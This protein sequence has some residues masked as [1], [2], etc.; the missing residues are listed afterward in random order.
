VNERLTF[1][2][3]VI[4]VI[5]NKSTTIDYVKDY[6]EEKRGTHYFLRAVVLND[7]PSVKTLIDSMP[8]DVRDDS[9]ST[10]LM[11]AAGN[12]NALELTRLL[13]AK[14]DAKFLHAK[15]GNALM[16]A[17]SDGNVE[18]VKLLMP[19]SDLFAKDGDGRT[20]LMHAARYGH[21]KI[22]SMLLP[23]SDALE[24][25][26]KG[27]NALMHAARGKH[28]ECVDKLKKSS[29]L[30]DK[31]SR[32]ETALH[33]AVYAQ[34][35]GCAAAL[36]ATKKGAECAKMHLDPNPPLHIAI[37]NGWTEMAALLA[38]FS[39]SSVKTKNG[40]TA[41]NLLSREAT[42]DEHIEIAEILAPFSSAHPIR[43]W[44]ELF[45]RPIH[46][47]I[48]PKCLAV[49]E[50]EEI[51]AEIEKAS[52]RGKTPIGK[53]AEVGEPGSKIKPVLSNRVGR[54]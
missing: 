24:K 1:S 2:H 54:L 3:C 18:G 35:V 10:P 4:E 9:G 29:S 13:L 12:K 34:S 45:A 15:H 21:E 44:L 20:A 30:T 37:I 27:E 46:A 8:I 19:V 5:V 42:R 31:N 23:L 52:M 6:M 25:D 11:I 53:E 22:V 33:V 47:R 16:A 39:D 50:A 41:W 40:Q 36:L 28:V 7:V 26:N 32:G 49:L 43:E 51:R 17:V 38:P 48:F 14:F